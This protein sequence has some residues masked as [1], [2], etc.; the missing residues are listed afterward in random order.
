MNQLLKLALISITRGFSFLTIFTIF[1]SDNSTI[2]SKSGKSILNDSDLMEEVNDKI[3][4]AKANNL[5]TG[6]II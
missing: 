3:I 4:K 6:V 1:S 2:V 5:Q